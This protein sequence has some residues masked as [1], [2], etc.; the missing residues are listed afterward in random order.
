M[1]DGR[2]I[3]AAALAVAQQYRN[4]QWPDLEDDNGGPKW[5]RTWSFLVAE[6]ERRCP[7]FTAGEYSHALNKA[8]TSTR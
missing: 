1:N 3:E 2:R 4:R 6:V 5:K 8:F 7:G